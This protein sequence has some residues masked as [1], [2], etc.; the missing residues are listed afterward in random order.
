MIECLNCGKEFRTVKLGACCD[1]PKREY[2]S[3]GARV[4]ELEIRVK[5]LE[6]QIENMKALI[7]A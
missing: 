3:I 6:E 1:K 5:F 7:Q 2:Q 4:L